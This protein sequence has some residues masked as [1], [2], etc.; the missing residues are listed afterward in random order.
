M[1]NFI[2]F[3]EEFGKIVYNPN[4]FN[5]EIVLVITGVAT[6]EDFLK[7]SYEATLGQRGTKYRVVK[8]SVAGDVTVMDKK[9]SDFFSK[10]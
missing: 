5:G 3:V 4:M 8:A 9:F 10:Y 1:P 7:E 6:K 2:P